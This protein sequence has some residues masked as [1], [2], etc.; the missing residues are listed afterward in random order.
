MQ[1]LAAKRKQYMQSRGRKREMAPSA[2]S[3]LSGHS[4]IP[5]YRFPTEPVK[6]FVAEVCAPGAAG[7]QAFFSDIR[8]IPILNSPG[9]LLKEARRHVNMSPEVYTLLHLKRAFQPGTA[10]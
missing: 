4:R 9:L 6:Y 8:L 7:L 1:V 5:I 3:Q 10:S 2:L